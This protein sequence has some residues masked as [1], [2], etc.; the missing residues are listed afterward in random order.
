MILE[1][2]TGISKVSWKVFLEIQAK[3]PSASTTII[4]GSP[5]GIKKFP[6]SHCAAYS[7]VIYFKPIAASIPNPVIQS[8]HVRIL[9][10]PS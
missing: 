3:I 6:K 10:D 9:I 2:C 4:F 1:T 5:N 7:N 8:R